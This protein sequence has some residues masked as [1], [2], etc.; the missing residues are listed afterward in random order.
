VAENKTTVDT[1][2]DTGSLAGNFLSDRVVR[3]LEAEQ[4]IYT[5]KANLSVCSGLD[6]TCYS[7]NKLLDVYI[8]Y[9]NEHNKL[10]HTILITVFIS[11]NS[12]ID[13]II[14]RATIKKHRFFSTNPSHFGANT[15]PT[16]IGKSVTVGTG[17]KNKNSQMKPS[18]KTDSNFNLSTSACLCT[19]LVPELTVT[20]PTMNLDSGDKHCSTDLH[21]SQRDLHP[22]LLRTDQFVQGNH[23]ATELPHPIRHNNVVA[24]DE[25]SD[26][27]DT[28][29]PFHTE[30]SDKD[31]ANF[32]DQITFE[33]DEDLQRRCKTLC[34]KYQHIFTDTLRPK[35][36]AIKPFDLTVDE[37]M[38]NT[39]S[40]RAPVRVQSPVKEAALLTLVKSMLALGVIVKSVSAY[41]SQ[42]IMVKKPTGAWRFCIDYRKLNECTPSVAW[43]IP[44]TKGIYTRI[45]NS[46]A[47]TFGVVDL[48][49]GY[50]QAPV[51]SNARRFT[52]F[53]CFAGIFE[54]TRLPFGLKA[55]PSYFQEQMAS[56]VLLGLIYMI[57]EM[58]LDDCIIYGKGNDQFLERL[59]EVFKRFSKHKILLQPKKCKFGLSKIE[60]VGREISKD[61]TSMTPEKVQSVAAFPKPTSN[62][63]MRSFL[64]LANYMRDFVPNHSHIAHPLHAMIDQTKGKKHPLVWNAA[65]EKAFIDLKT[66]I[67]KCPLLY[68]ANDSDPITLMTDASDYGIGGHLFQTVKGQIRTI[69]FVSKSLTEGQ[70]R[71][72]V[73]QKEAY[74]I[75]YC[76]THLEHLLRDRHFTIMTDHKNLIFMS[77]D[78]NAMVIRWYIALQE[79]DYSLEYVPGPQNAT[80]DAMSRLCVNRLTTTTTPPMSTTVSAI[81]P[82]REISEEHYVIIENCHNAECGHGGV[83]RT[84]KKIHSL[85]H[86]WLYLTQDVKKFIANCACCQKMSQITIPIHSLKYVASTYNTMECLNI[87]FVGPY[88]DDGYTLVI[89][90]TFTRWV[91]LYPCTA[92]NAQEA[93]R[94]LLQH[95]GRFGCPRAIRSD[96]GSHFAND[97]ITGFL[98]AMGTPHNLT[99]AYSSQENSMVERVNKEVN[100]HITA[101]T[102]DHNIVDDWRL[103]LPFVQ[104]II[105]SSYSQRTKISPADLLFGKQ[106]QLD[107]GLLLPFEER[108]A[109]PTPL[110]KYLA[111]MLTIQDT[112]TTM[113]REL[114]KS[115]DEKHLAQNSREITEF[116]VGTH[117]L[118]A[119]STGP[120]T[121]LLTRW[122]G[123]MKILRCEGSEYLLL[124]LVSGKEKVFHIKNMRP[125]HFIPS[126]IDP[127]DVA[128]H[129]YN[130]FFVDRIL[131]HEGDFKKMST[132]FFLVRWRTYSSEHDSWEP[133]KNLLHS[134][135]LHV[136]LHSIGK[137]R[138][139]PK[140]K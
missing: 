5:S 39:P 119:Y 11:E 134:E 64:G 67:S 86:Q 36:A 24:D 59:E 41:Y 52:A 77:L 68:F 131:E 53:I 46:G 87:D 14:G 109:M 82:D 16:Q 66:L 18:Q 35:P 98:L 33:G 116:V 15:K 91:E 115:Q 3:T 61:G 108:P 124:D 139:I 43:P 70:L 13:L 30:K 37:G 101:Y 104:R 21:R 29:A 123:P 58:Y 133:W 125:F 40:N 71:W 28:F 74:A 65:G 23:V 107:R 49:S 38:W 122:K 111:K 45:G 140:S 57:C 117:V 63:A 50:H 48:T 44:N 114:L 4:Y 20:L 31:Q 81:I 127:L 92:A 103:A 99:L 126:K 135:Q 102:F 132:L 34:Y 42:I 137:S 110:P 83:E 72:S 73:I 27:T 51:A 118:V 113:S 106:V 25:I 88:P 84:V 85:N 12:P 138:I 55:A 17:M 47:D 75:F 1:L 79:F 80:A 130:E 10:K 32:I 7:S 78:S 56:V 95:F 120:P 93:L 121:R 69:A 112:L 136:Y 96:R 9:E 105:N 90:D 2:L 26:K 76:C 54:F 6:N 60:Y 62:T 97:L 89:I 128:R 100:R 8:T 129:D 94:G 19:T 22:L